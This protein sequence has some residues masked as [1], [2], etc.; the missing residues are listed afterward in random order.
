MN[1]IKEI[2]HKEEIYKRLKKIEPNKVY[3]V[4]LK[5]R[6]QWYDY[7][8]GSINGNIYLKIFTEPN[9]VEESTKAFVELI[10]LQEKE[11]K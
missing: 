10:K 9:R 6:N 1:G 2:K 8:F 11:S 3:L 4:P 5:Y 7:V